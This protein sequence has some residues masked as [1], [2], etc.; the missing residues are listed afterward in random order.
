MPLAKTSQSAVY[1]EIAHLEMSHKGNLPQMLQAAEENFGDEKVIRL[2][3]RKTAI[4]GS[5][6]GGPEGV[7]Q[8]QALNAAYVDVLQSTSV[9]ARLLA[10]NALVPVPLNERV[11]N[12]TSKSTG[13]IRQADGYA[14]AVSKPSLA[15]HTVHVRTAVALVVE[16]DETVRFTG[17]AG[18]ALISRDVR[19][20]VSAAQDAQFFVV[21]LDSAASHGSTGDAL[22]DAA[23]ALQEVHSEGSSAALLYWVMSSDV[24]NMA[25]VVT[26][27]SGGPTLFEDMSPTGGQMLNLPALVSSVL[28]SGTLV[29]LD[30]AQIAG[31][32]QA[33]TFDSSNEAV[34]E[35][36]APP[37]NNEVTGAGAN[38]VS[39][40]QCNCTGL[41]VVCDFGVEKVGSNAVCVIEGVDWVHLQGS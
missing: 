28:P 9:F 3:R 11:V 33:F 30:A 13:L 8:D 26:S 7:L 37:T 25:T 22:R 31:A 16:S 40:Y 1:S 41:R 38:M 14:I 18:Q 24:A 6:I 29:L 2:I 39:L 19:L 27:T 34:V 4:G 35:M 17:A 20:A 36:S 32:Q 10:D 21:I 12:V 23:Q 5:S 15:A